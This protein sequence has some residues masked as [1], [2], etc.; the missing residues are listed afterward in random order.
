M[1]MRLQRVKAEVLRRDCLFIRVLITRLGDVRKIPLQWNSGIFTPFC[2]YALRALKTMDRAFFLFFFLFIFFFFSRISR[3]FSH[4]VTVRY[5]ADAL[6]IS[7]D[8]T[9][10]G[11]T[12]AWPMFAW[13][14]TRDIDLKTS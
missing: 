14:Y 13:V 4:L 10:R 11:Q 1:Q 7:N 2:I 3:I 5:A 9:G 6:K 8:I 12:R